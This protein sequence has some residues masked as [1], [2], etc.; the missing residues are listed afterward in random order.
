M[1]EPTFITANEIRAAFRSYLEEQDVDEVAYED[2]WRQLRRSGV[3]FRGA[4][5]KKE[6]D[7][8][9]NALV[10]DPEIERVRPGVFG[11]AE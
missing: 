11:L 10:G 7:S 2:L 6:R 8:V 1:S 4:T 3:S 9:Y 5:A